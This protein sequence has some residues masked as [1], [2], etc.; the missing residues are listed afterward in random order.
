[1]SRQSTSSHESPEMDAPQAGYIGGHLTPTSSAPEVRLISIQ[2]ST[3]S[4]FNPSPTFIFNQP[5]ITRRRKLPPE[6]HELKISISTPNLCLQEASE[7]DHCL[8]LP[9]ERRRNRLGYHRSAVACG[10]YLLP[11]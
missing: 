7:V 5:G 1:M 11:H 10:K 4:A 6:E 9:S 3:V 2:P 8:D